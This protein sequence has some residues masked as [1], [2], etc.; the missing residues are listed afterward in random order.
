MEAE[1]GNYP[2]RERVHFLG[3]LNYQDYLQALHAS[4]VHVHLSYP[5]VL[6]WSAIEAVVCG[7]TPVFS[8]VP[9]IREVFPEAG[10]VDFGDVEGLVDAVVRVLDSPSG[11]DG[12]DGRMNSAGPPSALR[13]GFS[14]DV[15][16]A[17][18]MALL[19]E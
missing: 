13:E 2:G 14:L 1:L 7:A 8:D 3:R 11:V 12:L 19:V 6:S 15:V 16:L 17:R 4:S 9:Q 10:Y 18:Q 5:F